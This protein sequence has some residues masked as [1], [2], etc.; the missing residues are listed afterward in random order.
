MRDPERGTEHLKPNRK[1]P[2]PLT[3]ETAAAMTRP[4]RCNV[5]WERMGGHII[6]ELCLSQ[7][8]SLKHVTCLSSDEPR[9]FRPRDH[10]A[11]LHLP[12]R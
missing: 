6:C 1:P 11:D 9:L 4:R 5:P 10:A 12:A 3:Y 7:C 2:A 8:E